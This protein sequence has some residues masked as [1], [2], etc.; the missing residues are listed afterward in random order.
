M[1]PLIE[2]IATAKSYGDMQALAPLDLSISAEQAEI[3]TI[4]GESG[5]GKSTL[6][7][8]ALGF[9]RPTSG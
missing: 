4:A 6:A 8:L 1:T 9:T 7:N 2:F 5:S 3:V